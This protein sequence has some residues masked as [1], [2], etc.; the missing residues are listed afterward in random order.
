MNDNLSDYSER[1][2]KAI[3]I[4]E[5]MIVNNEDIEI[6]NQEIELFYLGGAY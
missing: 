5:K 1:E 4:I 6:I 3:A 2:S